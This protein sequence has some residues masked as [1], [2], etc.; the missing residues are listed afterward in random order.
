MDIRKVYNVDE[1]AEILQTSPQRIRKLVN[2]GYLKAFRLGRILIRNDD[3]DNF[4]L[5]AVGKDFTDGDPVE[6]REA[7]A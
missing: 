6:L 7:K 3:L 2:G 5:S 4:L 1:V